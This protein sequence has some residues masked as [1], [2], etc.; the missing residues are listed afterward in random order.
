MDVPVFFCQLCK[1]RLNLTESTSSVSTSYVGNNRIL[2]ESFIVLDDKR[3][4]A[5]GPKGM[6]ESFVVLNSAS[7]L[8]QP[9]HPG[10]ATSNQ[11]CVQTQQSEGAAVGLD[12]KLQALSQ[13]FDIASLQTQVDH[14]L[15]LDCEV[16]LKDEIEAQI[17]EAEREVSAYA[18]AVAKLQS[19]QKMA[20][21]E[22]VFS[23]QMQQL[24]QEEEREKQ[25]AAELTAQLEQVQ[26]E[27]QACQ[28]AEAELDALEERY[29]HDY[30]AYQ[31]QLSF[32]VEEKDALLTKI[33]RATQRLHVLKN[34]N[35]YNDAFKIW[36]DGP[37]G[38]ISG[39]RLGRTSEVQ[40][41]WDEI[42]AAWG[43]AVLLLHTMSQAC[44]FTFSCRLLPMG[45][46]PRV[47][48]KHSTYDLFGPVNKLWSHKYDRAMMCYLTCLRE[49]GQAAV[50]EDTAGG[51][52]EPFKFPFPIDADKVN[53][54]T[55]KLTLNSDAKWTKALKFML[56]N[57]KVALQWMVKFK[58]HSAAAPQLR[59]LTHEGPSH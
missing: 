19:E 44:G 58:M 27:L 50:T 18:A 17:L 26:K 23:A 46:H 6:E 29:W 1:C 36:H 24:K 9:A 53:N 49:F 10:A 22:D 3:P 33:D 11:H 56:A 31:L 59:Q 16:Q 39:F 37:F 48:D 32:H 57:L 51:R 35:V 8:R 5:T 20:L 43:Q 42:N 45:S 14:P 7:M 4:G 54:Y 40:V 52:T 55:I 2:D 41:E 15:C 21:P 47:A 13:L 12:A 28:A 38:T 34:T 30:N 25:R